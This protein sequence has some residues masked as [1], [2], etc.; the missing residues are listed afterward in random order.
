MRVPVLSTVFMIISAIVQIGL[1]IY[2]FFYFRKRFNAKVIPAL[3]GVLGFVLFAIVLETAVHSAVIG[4]FHLRE[5]PVIYIIYGIF[6]AGIFEETARFAAFNILKKKYSGVETGLAYGVGHGGIESILLAG[7]STAVMAVTSILINTGNA[8]MVRGQ[9][10]GEVLA[11]INNQIEF[12]A[13]A[14]PYLFLIGA[15]ERVMAVCVQL[16]LSV[17]VFCSVYRKKLYLFPLAILLH[18]IVD[19]SAM[20]FQTGVI[21]NVLLVEGLILVCAAALLFL[22]KYIYNKGKGSGIDGHYPQ[23]NGEDTGSP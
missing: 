8:A 12:I 3:F 19:V 21:K 2:L 20:A 4:R 14:R 17:I 15:F 22:A 16:S 11:A 5:K 6:M 9:A 23:D 13:T 7:V 1:P 10:Q 18:A